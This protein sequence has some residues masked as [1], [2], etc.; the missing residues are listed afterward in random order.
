M[1]GKPRTILSGILPGPLLFLGVLGVEPVREQP[2]ERPL[3]AVIAEAEGVD[4]IKVAGW[5]NEGFRALVLVLDDRHEAG[6]LRKAAEAAAANSIDL[7]F[8][9]EVGRNEALARE[10]PE[11]MASLGSH[12]DWRKR[13]PKTRQA[14]KGEVAKAWPWVPITYR[15][16]FD[17]HLARVNRLLSRAPERYCG[18][19]LND[20]QGG[21]SSCGCG[22]TQCRWAV[23]YGVASTASKLT[24]SDVAARF[25]A[26]VSKS[27]H[28]RPVIPIWTPECEPE[29]LPAG[30]KPGPGWSTGYCG[31]VPCFETCRRR[32]AEQWNGLQAAYGM[33][34]P[35]ASGSGDRPTAL[36][37]LHREFQRD[38]KEYGSPAAWIGRAVHYWSKQG[39]RPFPNRLL[40]LVVQGYDVS[41]DEEAAARREASKRRVGAVLVSRVRIDQTFEPRFVRAKPAP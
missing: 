9:I 18:V 31:N 30:Q 22:N 15:E 7:Y 21:P 25:L 38:R 5:K 26:Q 32:F 6:T 36:L 40:W 28:T 1:P 24:G 23:D 33:A 14:E 17:A 11:W 39:T 10:H 35:G 37:L 13:F 12:D 27:L 8:W 16:S 4:S 34:S 20:L 29:D 2:E 41:S 3:Q 19:L